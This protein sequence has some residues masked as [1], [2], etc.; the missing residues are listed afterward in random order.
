MRLTVTIYSLGPGGAQRVASV[1]AAAWAA[2]GHDVIILTLAADNEVFFP[3]P[4]SVRVWRVGPATRS[5]RLVSRAVDHA[6]RFFRLRGELRRLS[7]D[8][9]VSFV[10]QVNVVTGLASIGL[11]ARL[12]MAERTDPLMVPISKGWRMLRDAAYRLADVVVFQTASAARGMRPGLRPRLRVIPNPV[13]LPDLGATPTTD[14]ADGHMLL[15]VGRLASE[16]GLD[17]L[18]QAFARVA[19]KF[20]AWRLVVLGEGPKRRELEVLVAQ[21]GLAGRVDLPGAVADVG[22]YYRSADL[23]VLPSRFEGFPNALCEAMSWGV[24]AIASDC[25]S[26]PREISRD[27]LDAM[28]V[29]P[30][31]PAALAAALARLM[32]DPAE[33]Q[34]L[35]SAGRAGI[36]RYDLPVILAA[37][38]DAVGAAVRPGR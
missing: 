15:A 18:I 26:G 4:P 11:G 38:D 25:P 14:N 36:E 35:G 24:P 5:P 10:D 30:E 34:R 22:A 28:L 2:R 19:E 3:L 23:F 20:P 37:W 13:T 33:R 6:R 17:V 31:D 1:L 27:G 16:K 9:V 8:C 32:S 7:P 29:P 12:V 21:R